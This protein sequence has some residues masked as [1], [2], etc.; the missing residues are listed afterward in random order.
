MCFGTSPLD[1]LINTME[2]VNDL[3]E[4][5]VTLSALTG[6][7]ALYLVVRKL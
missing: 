6:V 4:T 1:P 5:L 7:V 2:E 3:V